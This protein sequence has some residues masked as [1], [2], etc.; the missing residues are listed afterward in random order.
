MYDDESNTN[1]QNVRGMDTLEV[2]LGFYVKDQW[3]HISD[4]LIGTFKPL[5]EIQ[6]DRTK[7][8]ALRL[9]TD[10][11]EESY[12]QRFEKGFDGNIE[13]ARSQAF[14]TVLSSEENYSPLHYTMDMGEKNLYSRFKLYATTWNGYSRGG[15]H[16]FELYGTND[17][18]LIDRE[19]N[20]AWVWSN[21]DNPHET[22]NWREEGMDGWEKIGDFE[23]IK[24]S[25]LPGLQKINDIDRPFSEGG[26]EFLIP[27][28]TPPYRYIRIRQIENWD[29]EN[30]TVTYSEIEFFGAP[31]NN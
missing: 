25:G 29:T 6:L 13:T 26:M 4:T 8:K 10:I 31:V 22:G 3:G 23:V 27:G 18:N 20:G 30:K 17:Q 15:M 24:A 11:P 5:Y 19:T 14:S 16:F 28:G 9:D 7:W 21:G 1:F 12:T 2:E